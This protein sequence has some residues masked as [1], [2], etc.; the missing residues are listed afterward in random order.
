M[1]KL[2]N[3]G[4]GNVVNSRKIVAVVSPDAAPVKR[5][6]QS[7]KGTRTDRC[8]TGKKNKSSDRYFR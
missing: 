7:V 3:V 8:H 4:F 1:A 2:I 6:I 5:M